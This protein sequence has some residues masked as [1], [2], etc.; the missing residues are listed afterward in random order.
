MLMA[1][2]YVYTKK[3]ELLYKFINVIKINFFPNYLASYNIDRIK[4]IK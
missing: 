1:S 3:R 4:Y 2:V